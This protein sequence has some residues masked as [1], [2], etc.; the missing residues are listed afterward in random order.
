MDNSQY[1]KTLW[2]RW[3]NEKGEEIANELIQYYLHVVDY[4]VETIAQHIPQSFDKGDLKSLGIMGLYDALY[5]YDSERN[6]KFTTYASIRVHGSIMDGLRKEDWLPRTLRE[7]ANKIEKTSAVLEQRL[8]RIPTS[9][10]IAEEL[11]MEVGE[12]EEAVSDTLFAKVQSLD[13]SFQNKESDSASTPLA[14]IYDNNTKTPSEHL[15]ANDLREELIEHIKQLGRNEQMVISL[16]YVEEL[17][18]TEVGEVLD[19]ST[20]RISQIH[21]SAIFKLRKILEKAQYY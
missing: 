4:H 21:K 2:K 5:K 6:V 16:V 8:N 13:A 9:T 7:K 1:E 17:S 14:Y 3:K 12:V 15:L 19:L 11:N 10:D 18:L 20:S